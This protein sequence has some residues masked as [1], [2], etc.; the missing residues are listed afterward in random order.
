MGR[1]AT[2]GVFRSRVRCWVTRVSTRWVRIRVLG[3]LVEITG[4]G[5]D[6]FWYRQ[7]RR[8]GCS[9]AELVEIARLGV[10]LGE[11]RLALIR[12][13]S[14]AELVEIIRLGVDL[15]A[16]WQARYA[17]FTHGELVE[18]VAVHGLPAGLLS[19]FAERMDATPDADVATVV[20]E[21]VAG[22]ATRR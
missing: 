11:Y 12:G 13:R 6:W 10:D 7:A 17:G 4:L 1:F 16:Y 14:H 3:E 18:V 9:H 5:G 8:E 20:F 19:G 2:P 21:T 15:D 22:V